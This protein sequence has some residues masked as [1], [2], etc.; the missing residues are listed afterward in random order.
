MSHLQNTREY[1]AL[2]ESFN[3][4]PAFKPCLKACLEDIE[5]TLRDP[6]EPQLDIDVFY[7]ILSSALQD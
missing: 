6:E 7:K 1:R 4:D 3:N 2:K 5:E